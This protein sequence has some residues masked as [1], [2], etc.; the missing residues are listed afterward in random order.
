VEAALEKARTAHGDAELILKCQREGKPL[1]E[2]VAAREKERGG[3][4]APSVEGKMTLTDIQEKEEIRHA[5][6]FMARKHFEKLHGTKERG[7]AGKA[8]SYMGGLAKAGAMKGGKALGDVAKR[9]AIAA[10]GPAVVWGT[11]GAVGASILTPVIGPIASAVG[12]GGT[13]FGFWGA[14]AGAVYGAA[15]GLTNRT[16]VIKESSKK[17]EKKVEEKK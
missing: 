17:E 3:A 11:V 5:F 4:A 2:D 9:A 13:S 6:I 16:V 7:A 8:G 12:Y 10:A 14:V 1:P 15:K